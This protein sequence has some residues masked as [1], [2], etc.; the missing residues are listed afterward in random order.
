MSMKHIL[1]T[2]AVQLRLDAK[3]GEYRLELYVDERGSGVA[4]LEGDIRWLESVIVKA[5]RLPAEMRQTMAEW[6]EE[7]E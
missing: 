3:T 6:L 2:G 7:C 5:K 1:G 4:D